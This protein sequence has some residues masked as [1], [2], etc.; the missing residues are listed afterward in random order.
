M[1][2]KYLLIVALVL[3]TI[4]IITQKEGLSRDEPPYVKIDHDMRE[5][6]PEPCR[7]KPAPYVGYDCALDDLVKVTCDNTGRDFCCT[8]PCK[9]VV[10][11]DLM[12]Y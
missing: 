9:S 12:N 4:V 11:N 6:A 5:P 1:E 2:V 7:C 10:C 8:V 3:I